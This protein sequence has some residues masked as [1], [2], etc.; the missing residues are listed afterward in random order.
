MLV[1]VISIRYNASTVAPAGMSPRFFVAFSFGARFMYGF[2]VV[3]VKLAVTLVA[4]VRAL[5]VTLICTRYWFGPWFTLLWSRPI[6]SHDPFVS[7]SVPSWK[8][9]SAERVSS[10]FMVCVGI[11]WPGAIAETIRVFSVE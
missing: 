9:T 10:R 2:V 1:L 5:L 4:V 11:I 6:V 8:F 3:H 7:V